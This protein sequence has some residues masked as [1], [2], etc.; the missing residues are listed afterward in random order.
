[1]QWRIIT[2][3]VRKPFG[4][5]T[6]P[7][8]PYRMEDIV[9]LARESVTRSITLPGVQPKLSLDFIKERLKNPNSGRLTILDALDG[10]FILKPQMRPMLKCRR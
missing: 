9:E 7:I 1:M 5:A 4:T 2:R 8:F 10:H 6:A 3:I